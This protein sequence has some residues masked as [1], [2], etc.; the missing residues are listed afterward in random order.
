MA[1]VRYGTFVRQLSNV[2]ARRDLAGLTDGDLWQRYLRE[3]NEAAFETLVRRHG[4]MVMGVC[5][6]VLRNDQDAE[7]AFQATFLVLVRAGS[8][9]QS[10]VKIANWLYGVAYRTAS[11]AR[12]AA[13]IRRAREAKVISRSPSSENR[14]AE[15]WGVLD[16]ELSRLPEKYRLAILLCDLEGRT[17]HDVAR[18]LGCPEGTMASRLARGRSL[19]AVR[20]ARRGFPAVLVAQALADGAAGASVSARLV[21]PIT[22]AAC[23]SGVAGAVGNSLLTVNV[24]GLAEGVMRSMLLTKI[25]TAIAVCLMVAMTA[26]GV[27]GSMSRTLAGATPDPPEQGRANSGDFL[28][29]V[30]KLKAQLQQLQTK[31]VRLEA[32]AHAHHDGGDLAKLFKHRVPFEIGVTES[33]EGGRIEI[34]EVR[35]TRPRIEVG[36]QYLVVGKYVLPRGERGKLYL[37]QTAEWSQPSATL[38]LQMA[39]ADKPEGEFTLLHGMAGPGYFHVVLAHPDRYSRMFANVYFG[40]GDHVLRKK[41]W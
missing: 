12:R 11:E 8:L 40:T 2:L 35:G 1:A 23:C 7:D 36:G 3:R 4:P 38:D 6:R 15:L 13:A 31:V 10:P 19:L 21:H 5:R 17:R 24:T 14:D 32:E 30:R 39:D 9:R 34:L 29:R 33:N 28:D 20:L 41:N 22:T 16:E 25:K 18:Q 26:V 27:G 37:Y